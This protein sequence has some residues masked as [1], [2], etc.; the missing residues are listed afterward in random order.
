MLHVSE[1]L[2]E[3]ALREAKGRGTDRHA[4]FVQRLQRRR[5]AFT[6]TPDAL[7]STDEHAFEMEG[8]N[9]MTPE[10]LLCGRAHVR[11]RC[12]DDEGSEIALRV[13]RIFELRKD[14]VEVRDT[15]VGDVNLLARE[16][17]AIAVTTC[18]GGDA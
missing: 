6:F 7:V 17:V 3:R 12:I 9:R 14:D 18:L 1:R 2:G 11:Q 13:L 8:T 5:Q 16:H 4:E 10:H 15:R